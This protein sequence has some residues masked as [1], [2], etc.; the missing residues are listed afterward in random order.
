MHFYATLVQGVPVGS[1]GRVALV[2]KSIFSTL[3]MFFVRYYRAQ[4]Q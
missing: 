1:N 2:K 4:L 3:K